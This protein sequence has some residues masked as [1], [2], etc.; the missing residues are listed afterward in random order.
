[1]KVDEEK[2]DFCCRARSATEGFIAV[3]KNLRGFGRSL[4]LGLE[5]DKIWALVCQIGYNLKKFVQC[6]LNDEIEE[7]SLVKLGLA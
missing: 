1:L 7:E 6:Y 3:A 2:R 5:G 4:Y